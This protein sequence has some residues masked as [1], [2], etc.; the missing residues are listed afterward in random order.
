MTKVIIGVDPHK[1]S[2]PIEVVD[3]HEKLLG[4]GRF[5]TDQAGTSPEG[6]RPVGQQE[7]ARLSCQHLAKGDRATRERIAARVAA[8]QHPTSRLGQRG[9]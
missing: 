6:S 4:S 1:L 3:D 9:L 7:V 5:D 8:S 2:A